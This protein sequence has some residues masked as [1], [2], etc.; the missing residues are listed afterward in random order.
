MDRGTILAEN[1]TK[2]RLF[3]HMSPCLVTVVLIC[4]PTLEATET[5]D[6]LD[7]HV[8]WIPA[9]AEREFLPSAE[10]GFVPPHPTLVKL[11]VYFSFQN[12]NLWDL[13]I[14]EGKFYD[15]QR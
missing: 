4:H 1:R 9:T 6:D 3:H 5:F 7:P 2:G 8:R 14:W 13:V 10:S 15:F 11:W 12:V